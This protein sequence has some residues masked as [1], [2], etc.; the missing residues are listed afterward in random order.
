M[1]I[2]DYVDD[3]NSSKSSVS[4]LDSSPRRQVQLP[5]GISWYTGS[6]TTDPNDLYTDDPS[7]YFVYS[8]GWHQTAISSQVR[9]RYNGVT[10]TLLEGGPVQVYVQAADEIFSFIQNFYGAPYTTSGDAG[11]EE[12]ILSTYYPVTPLDPESWA[13]EIPSPGTYK[14]VF[15]FATDSQAFTVSHSGAGSYRVS[16]IIPR[17]AVQS[18]DIDVNSIKAY[19][20][21]AELIDTISLRVSD[22]IVVGPELIGAKSIDGSK[23]VDGT[24]SGILMRDG[25]VTGNKIL[26]G[27]ISGV[28]I[29]GNTIT[30][31]NIV[32]GTVSGALITAGTITAAKIAVGTITG[33]RIAA[34]TISGSLLTA[35][36]ITFDKIASNTL[37]AGQI[38]DGTITGQKIVAGTVSGVLITDNAITASKISANTIT[39]DKIA[40]NTI[41]GALITAGT[42][43]ADNIATRTITADRIVLS[44]IVANL[45][46]PEA[47]TA[48]AL[49]SGAVISGKLAANSILANN[50][51]AGVIQG[52]HVAADTIT[53]ANIA[54][55][56]ISGSLITAGTITFDK[57]ASN[58]L[59]S[60]QIAN[61]TITGQNILAGTVSGVLITDG[62]IAASKITANTITASQIAA[63]TITATEIAANTITANKLS[64]NQLDAVA[65]NMGNLVVNSGIS[66]GTQGYLWAGAGSASAPTTGLK[67]YTT[68]GVSRFTTYSNSTKQIDID[69]TGSLTAGPN[70]AVL[71]NASGLVFTSPYTSAPNL[72]SNRY[73][74]DAA[75][76]AN[77]SS[78]IRWK[79]T[80]YNSNVPGQGVAGY[81]AG[82]YQP[83]PNKVYMVTQAG[84]NVEGWTGG[85]AYP[86]SNEAQNWVTAFSRNRADVVLY[87]EAVFEYTS[88]ANLTL[89][90]ELDATSLVYRSSPGGMLP[91]NI[92]FAVNDTGMKS[93]ASN[94]KINVNTTISGTLNVSNN[95]S[96]N[97]NKF[98]IASAT[99]NTTISGTILASNLLGTNTGDQNMPVYGDGA[100]GYVDFNG[101]NPNTSFATFNQS[102]TYTLTRDVFA[103]YINVNNSI[104]VIT[105]GYRLFAQNGISNGGTIHNNGS[106]GSGTTA[107]AGGLGGFFKAGGAGAAGLLAASAGA[108]GT[109]QATPTAN[110]WVGGV[111]GKGGQGRLNNTG[112][113]GGQIT[114]ANVTSPA[115]ADGGSKVTSN[116]IN[117]LTRYVVGAT[118][119]QMTPSIGGGGG[120]KSTTGTAAT[121]GAGGGGG[122]ICFVAA[123]V[124]TGLGTISANGGDGGN[125]AGTGGSFGGGGGG[126]GGVMCMI[127]KTSTITPTATGGTGGTSVF[128]TNGTLPIAHAFGTATTATQTLTLTPAH[129]LSKGKLYLITVHLNVAAGLDGSGINSITGYGI[130]WYNLSGSRVE[131]ATIA[132]P[133]RAQE[134]W[135]GFYTGTEPDLVN[136]LDIVINL[137]NQNTSARAIMDEISGVEINTAVT[138]NIATNATNSATTLTTTLVTAPTTGNMVYSVFTRSGGT[139][140]VAGA[141]NVLLN[142][143]TVAPQIVSQVS[144][145]QQA[146]IQTH[147]TAAAV[148][149][150]SVE[151]TASVSG[152]NGSD[153]W[154]GKVVRIYG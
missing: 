61:G 129:P 63:G 16:Q 85:Y 12:L 102:T 123:P 53:G 64:V 45:L 37:T 26:A 44:G 2:T 130:N 66:I 136:S 96:V 139:T 67:I 149:G 142:S 41:S 70:N 57:I 49:A 98:T 140:P 73:Y 29:A 146:N 8:G 131:Y 1:S 31:N 24:I 51:T 20:V 145:A 47:V 9:D 18:Y 88:A 143:Q 65:A 25:T 33:D 77:N 86:Y 115:N 105:A 68:S 55:A 83:A 15:P 148:A 154:A 101:N 81:T 32:A 128:G 50:V 48:A 127:A 27:T 60:G 95:F 52:Y 84:G 11:S 40:A 80:A 76:L 13:V 108:A 110:T 56:T 23:I 19:H 71:L 112:F 134:T 135:Y 106:A 74:L 82:F 34:T 35:G 43:T 99:G 141:G 151:L 36:T 59:T 132:A 107:G 10:I 58:T 133:T 39:G 30:G 94:A 100:D 90:A 3:L 125:A 121:S 120:A 78:I 122:G 91:G 69:S 111:G 116:Y 87:A 75:A 92:L 7:L 22:S 124:I 5:L 6:G 109:A 113:N 144:S 79:S 119:W 104:T 138:G 54:A 93:E 89:H 118:N 150:F 152:T 38:A 14:I 103:T 46:G 126:G 4:Y 97:N 114:Y 117:Y 62:T 42:I 21:T 137:S 28:L 147:T 17:R 72:D 153:G